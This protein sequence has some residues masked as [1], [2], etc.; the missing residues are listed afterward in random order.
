MSNRHQDSNEARIS[1]HDEVKRKLSR[2]RTLKAAVAS[3]AAWAMTL[4]ALALPPPIKVTGSAVATITVNF[5]VAPPSGSTVSCSLLLISNDQRAPS[6]TQ[7]QDAA[8]SGSAATCNI[9]LH[10]KWRLTTPASDTLTIAYSVQGTTQ[11][12]S[13]LYDI[14]AQ[15]ADGT[16]TIVNIGVVQ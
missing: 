10:Y 7:S 4:P 15:P 8:V 16:P 12:S 1:L 3:F 9:T 14:I 6:D 11:T 5:K 2:G 13:G